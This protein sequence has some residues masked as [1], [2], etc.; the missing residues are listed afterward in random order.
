MAFRKPNKQNLTILN[1]SF[2]SKISIITIVLLK[3][4][5]GVVSAANDK[6][7]V[8][9]KYS[10]ESASD[11]GSLSSI[12]NKDTLKSLRNDTLDVLDCPDFVRVIKDCAEDCINLITDYL[13]SQLT[14]SSGENDN[15]HEVP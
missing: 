15:H 6:E 10:A 2:R 4:C 9:Q 11:G 8:S 7:Q 3:E 14:A 1:R 12:E 5:I 13:Q